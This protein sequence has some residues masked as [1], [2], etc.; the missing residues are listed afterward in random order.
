[1]ISFRTV[2]TSIQVFL[3]LACTSSVFAQTPQ[4][5]TPA[6][7]QAEFAG[8]TPEQVKEKVMARAAAPYHFSNT[9]PT[10]FPLPKYTSNVTD[11]RFVNSTK[12]PA[13]ATATLTTKDA[14]ETVYQFYLDACKRDSW[15]VRTPTEKTAKSLANTPGTTKL[16][17]FEGNK[18]NRMIRVFCT[19]NPK[20][21]A[22]TLSIMWF[23]TGV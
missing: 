1:M 23:K 2:T 19:Q 10:N 11:T 8:M 4:N 5:P 22:T 17:M 18:D 7:I 3:V 9:W 21:N 15:N 12:G 6:Q 13:Q 14:A 20:T 16:L